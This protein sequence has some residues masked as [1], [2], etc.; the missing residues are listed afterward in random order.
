MWDITSSEAK[1][2]KISN[3]SRDSYIQSE[4]STGIEWL[5]SYISN[6]GPPLQL[7]YSNYAHAA[8]SHLVRS[9]A[10]SHL[11]RPPVS[12]SL[13][14]ARI[15]TSFLHRVRRP[16]QDDE[17]CLYGAFPLPSHQ[18]YR[19]LVYQFHDYVD[20]VETGIDAVL[21]SIETSHAFIKV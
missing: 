4:L 10:L 7:R 13:V 11:R 16:R 18:Q 15:L 12:I 19:S 9:L 14:L 1:G 20:I 17:G 3:L 6:P 8:P 2:D 21:R 5:G